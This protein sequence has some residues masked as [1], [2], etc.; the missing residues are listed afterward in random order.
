MFILSPDTKFWQQKIFLPL[1]FFFENMNYIFIKHF[2][3]YFLFLQN[4]S[5]FD[6]SILME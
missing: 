5:K 6:L 3:I 1:F 2:S 4:E